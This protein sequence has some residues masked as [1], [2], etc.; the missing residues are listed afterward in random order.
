MNSRQL[1]QKLQE[2]DPSGEL[3]VLCYDSDYNCCFALGDDEVTTPNLYC[4]NYPPGDLEW[5]DWPQ[6]EGSGVEK[7][8]VLYS[9]YIGVK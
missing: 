5:K 7:K 9:A 1:I 4:H 6:E 8:L 3:E 2:L